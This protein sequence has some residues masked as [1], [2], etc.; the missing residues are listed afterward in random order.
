MLLPALLGVLV[1]VPLAVIRAYRAADEGVV[2]EWAGAHDLPLTPENRPMVGWYLRTAG[3]LRAW[4]AIGG[5][6]LPAA[7][8]L[9]WSGHFEVLGIDA[10]GGV[11]P[12]DVGWIFVGYLVGALYAEVCLVRPVDPDRRAA[13]LVPRDLDH[14]LP[15]R[16]LWAQRSLGGAVIAGALVSLALPYD[17]RWTGPSPA[18]VVGFLVWVAVVTV[19][20]ECLERWLVRRPQPFTDPSLVAADDAIRSQSVHSVAGSGLAVLLLM[21]AGISVLLASADVALLRWTMWLPAL[22]A[23]LLALGACQL[24]SPGQHG[25]RVRRP[26]A[27]PPAAARG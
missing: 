19:G 5:L 21:F 1:V 13:S 8:A 12:G 26:P 16:L 4:G 15:R 25:W 17:E 27:P 9:A 24:S 6:V 10:D 20:L 2:A 7:F 3:I 22:A 18:A 11:N 23:A 14:Y